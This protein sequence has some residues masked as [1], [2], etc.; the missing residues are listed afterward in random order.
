MKDITTIE[1]YKNLTKNEN[2]EVFVIYKHSS[3]CS[4][5]ASIAKEVQSYLTKN[6]D[7][8][9]K[10]YRVLVIESRELS[11]HI[12]KTTGIRHESPQILVIKNGVCVWTDSHTRL[13]QENLQKNIPNYLN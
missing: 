8:D 3:T 9:H 12:A 1:E 6:P 11:N 10:F 2:Q 7:L 5:S 4:L 13:K